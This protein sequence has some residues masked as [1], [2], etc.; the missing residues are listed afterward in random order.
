MIIT[1]RHN[2][3][4][5]LYA[6]L[7]D[8]KGRISAGGYLIEGEKQV[9]EA[10]K[11]GKN[12]L[13]VMGKA[14]LVSS[15]EGK[16]PAVY[17]VTDDICRFVADSVTPQ[18]I[19]ALVAFPQFKAKSSGNIVL[20][21]GVSDP[22]NVGTIIRT[23]AA[24]GVKTVYI[25]NGADPYSPK[26]VRSAMSGLNSVEVYPV[27]EGELEKVIENRRV[28]VADMGGE[29]L[30]GKTISGDFCL[31]IGNEAHGVS[32]KLK[33][34]ADEVVSIPMKSN[35][36]SLNA[37]VSCSIILYELLHKSI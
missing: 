22:G 8:K 5:K 11:S 31:V 35:M 19:F 26:C 6:S 12:V 2:P 24:V 14:R 36:E 23:C 37:G 15:Y 7:K 21:D 33:E 32:E 17:E 13:S 1:S 25:L 29:N 34:R 27:E 9:F 20:L 3:V 18:G 16:V 10:V 30:F 28:I 4:V